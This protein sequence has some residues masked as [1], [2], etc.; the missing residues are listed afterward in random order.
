MDLRNGIQLATLD[1]LS[2]YLNTDTTSLVEAS[3]EEFIEK[4]L[5][6]VRRH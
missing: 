6:M 2:V 5:S 4:F 3:P 1:S